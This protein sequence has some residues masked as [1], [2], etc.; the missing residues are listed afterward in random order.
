[1]HYKPSVRETV[2]RFRRLW[3]RESPDRVLVKIDIQ[4]P[5]APTVM[6]A[7]SKAPRFGEMVDEWEA[8]FELNR[9]IE[10]DNLPVAYGE[11]G[12]YIVGGFLGA[13]VS[14]G[15]GGA[16]PEKLILDMKRWR[17][18]V[19]FD[20]GN[21]YYLLHMGY[22]RYLAG[23]SAGRFGFTEMI[24]IDG[25]NFL[26]CVRHGDAYTDIYD[27]PAEVLEVMD[28]ASD[29]TVKLVRE[30][31]K[32]VPAFEGGQFNFYQI[33]TPGETIFISVDA[34]GQ[35]GPEVFEKFGRKYVQRL[36]DE[37]GGG[38]LHVH[39]DA[40]RLLPAYASLGGLVAIGLEDW[41]K[42]PFA[43]DHLGEI[44]GMTGDTPLM[45]NVDKERLLAMIDSRTLPGNTLYWVSGV[46]SADE[47]NRV[48][49]IARDY[50]APHARTLY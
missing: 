36:A 50:R 40:M 41:I 25:F 32:I 43:V 18:Y 21:E 15:A 38:W 33:W 4:N 10:D 1:M 31:R 28:Y 22:L 16:Y 7:M 23:R 29:L 49:E 20:E 6:N 27:Y 48:A 19:R 44:R 17:D 45:I 9:T 46:P 35:C 37:F 14:W 47:A 3:A 34:Y 42:P 39:S 2:D 30:Q 11:L 26:D 24:A 12:G 8:G 5:D 13:K